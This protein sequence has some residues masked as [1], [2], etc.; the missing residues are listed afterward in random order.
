MCLG[1]NAAAVWIKGRSRL[2]FRETEGTPPASRLPVVFGVAHL[3]FS[4][5]HGLY[6]D[7]GEPDG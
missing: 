4:L 5:D 6:S 2:Y 7:L 1:R 3:G